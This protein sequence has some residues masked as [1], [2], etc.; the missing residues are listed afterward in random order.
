MAQSDGL[1]PTS[2]LL[3]VVRPGATSSVLA[4][5]DALVPSERVLLGGSPAFATPFQPTSRAVRLQR[6][7]S[8]LF[9]CQGNERGEEAKSDGLQPTS[10]GLLPKTIQVGSNRGSCNFKLTH[11]LPST[12]PPFPASVWLKGSHPKCSVGSAASSAR[13]TDQGLL[14]FRNLRQEAEGRW[15]DEFGT[16]EESDVQPGQT[17][18]RTGQTRRWTAAVGSGTVVL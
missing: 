18:H 13:G 10:D 4:S 7:P 15:S 17:G 6:D 12:S 1:Q 8:D 2:F 11:F 9:S 14:R 3:L 5:S 16:S